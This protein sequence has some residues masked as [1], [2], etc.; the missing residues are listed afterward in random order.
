MNPWE[1]DPVMEEPWLEDPEDDEDVDFDLMTAVKNVPGSAKQYGQDIWNAVTSPVETA[2]AFGGMAS[3]GFNQ[4]QRT[5]QEVA[6]GAEIEPEPG[7]EEMWNAVKQVMVD[8][9]G[10]VDKFKQTMMDDPV[11]AMADIATLAAPL[12]KVPGVA[13]QVGRIGQMGDLGNAA[14]KVVRAGA[15]AIPDGTAE[16]LYGKAAKFGTTLKNRERV[17]DTLIRE[18]VEPTKAGIKKFE[19]KLA[20]TEAALGNAIADAT[21][22]GELIPKEKLYQYVDDLFDSKG[23]VKA[24]GLRDQGKVVK[25]VGEVMDNISDKKMLTPAEVQAFKVDLY[26]KIYKRQLSSDA[27]KRTG[28]KTETQET[29]ARGARHA[30]EDVTPEAADI[31]R[32]LGDLYTSRKPLSQST[33]RID[34]ANVI[35]T[36]SLF[37]GAAGGWKAALAAAFVDHPKLKSKLA[38]AIDSLKKGDITAAEKGLNSNEIRAALRLSEMSQEELEEMGLNYESKPMQIEI[39][40]GRTP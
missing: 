27:N 33:A 19:T 34:N 21:E 10:S 18:R 39:R 6:S 28:V 26:D 7:Q 32:L 5:I 16:K 35:P 23:G 11:G 9:Y 12:A 20:E 40:N 4:L 29:I 15:K 13:G 38:F 31:N 17:I 3:G 14:S 1:T 24:E 36:R 8:R 37:A 22:R 30:L 25:V 2:K